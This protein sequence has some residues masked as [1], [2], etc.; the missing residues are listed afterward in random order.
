MESHE[1]EQTSKFMLHYNFPPF[2]CWRSWAYDRRGQTSEIGHGALAWARD[3]SGAAGVIKSRPTRCVWSRDIREPNG[4]SSMATVC[5]A[6]LSSM[7]AGIPIKGAVA[8]VAMGLVKEGNKYAVLTDI[9]GAED[10]YGDMDFIGGWNPQRHHRAQEMDIAI[11]GI[12]A[13]I[14]REAMEQA[15]RGT[16]SSCWMVDGYAV[17]WKAAEEKT[18]VCTAHSHH[19]DSDRTRFAT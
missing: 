11:M 17:I 1:G 19:P 4:P 16:A 3:G 5:G 6:S 14:M 9:A 7:Q 13:Q 8:G 18:E 2:S 12:T 10:H 15:R